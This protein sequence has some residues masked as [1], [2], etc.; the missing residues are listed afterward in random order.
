MMA[1]LSNVLA[2]VWEIPV[3]EGKLLKKEDG[4]FY[5]ALQ[6]DADDL[7]GQGL[8]TF[9]DLDYRLDS[10]HQ[11]RLRGLYSLNHQ[12]ADP[13]LEVV[14]SFP[15]ELQICEFCQEL[16][17]SLS[18]VSN[19]EIPLLGEE[20]A[21]YGDAVTDTGN[22]VDF[23]EWRQTNYAANA[24]HKLGSLLRRDGQTSPGEMIQSYI[25]HMTRRL[26]AAG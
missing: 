3:L 17:L 23:A 24:A 11:W 25:S 2:P 14:R 10:D 4:P 1:Y 15:E 12:L 26:Y 16:A 13:V 18:S 22:V 20:D 8:L 9:S 5:P 19:A 21:T 6:A 7:I